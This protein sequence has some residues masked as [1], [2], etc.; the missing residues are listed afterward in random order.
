MFGFIEVGTESEVCSYSL[1]V[2][3]RSVAG[4]NELMFCSAG[5]KFVSEVANDALT[6][7]KMRQAGKPS[8]QGR[9]GMHTPIP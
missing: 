6:H 8:L 5:Q 3:N 9:Y 4:C 2:E 1:L 7:C